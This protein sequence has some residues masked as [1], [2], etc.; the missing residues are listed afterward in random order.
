MSMNC[1]DP[2]RLTAD[3]VE[4]CG[5]ASSPGR[6]KSKPATPGWIAPQPSVLDSLHIYLS[7]K[8]LK[9]RVRLD[10]RAADIDEETARPA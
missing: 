7:R 2:Y 9:N 8:T 4:H 10:L 5:S 3:Q 6:S 1:I